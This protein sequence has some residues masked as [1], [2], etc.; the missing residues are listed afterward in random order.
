MFK[1]NVFNIHD[2][3]CVSTT[4][5]HLDKLLQST[6]ALHVISMYTAYSHQVALH[7][8]QISAVESSQ[9][10][11][12]ALCAFIFTGHIFIKQFYWTHKNTTAL[13]NFIIY[14]S[15]RYYPSAQYTYKVVGS[16]KLQ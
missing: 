10:K 4:L 2:T 15:L 11:Q 12:G 5:E 8:E 16:S 9:Y 7:G 14:H 6:I 1:V 3:E 13:V